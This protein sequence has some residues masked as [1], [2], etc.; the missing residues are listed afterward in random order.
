[1]ELAEKQL[2]TLPNLLKGLESNTSSNWTRALKIQTICPHCKESSSLSHLSSTPNIPPDAKEAGW[3]EKPGAGSK[4]VRFHFLRCDHMYCRKGIFM[5]T[6]L[7]LVRRDGVAGWHASANI[8][9]FALDLHLVEKIGSIFSDSDQKNADTIIES[10]KDASICEAAGSVR[11]A[12]AMYR[13]ALEQ[14]LDLLA[15]KKLNPTDQK[16]YEKVKMV[17]PKLSFINKKLKLDQSR[18][19]EAANTIKAFGDDASHKDAYFFNLVADELQNIKN[20][21]QILI[22]AVAGHTILDQMSSKKVEPPNS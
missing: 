22:D 16:A 18:L 5:E 6:S 2:I 20:I 17:G 21:F 3:H 13:L 12:G 15:K 9:P 8:F 11:G 10:L 19:V 14:L 1:M 7:E 4:K